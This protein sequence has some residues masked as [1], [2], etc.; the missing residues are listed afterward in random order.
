MDF[1]G[2]HVVVSG[3]AGALGRAVVEQLIGRGAHCHVPAFGTAEGQS[4]QASGLDR[5]D[6]AVGV[7]LTDEAQVRD[8][9]AR[10]PPPWASLHITGG[11]AMAP[12]AETSRADFMGQLEMNAVTC[13]LCCREAVRRMR[14][15]GQGGRIVNVA[16]RPA[17][18]PRTGAGMAAYT[19]SKAAVAA[20][21][22]SLAEEVAGDGIWINAVAPSIMDTPANRGAMPG[23]DFAAWPKV[24][25][26]ATTM[27]HLASPGNGAA[28]GAVVPVYG[29]S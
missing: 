9:Y 8:F 15:G 19:A 23:A 2:R 11:F 14:E 27:L 21:T 20:L 29:R 13:F 7:D 22:Q 18:E 28:R 10:L 16:A 25:E 26:V 24:E 6:V 4:L 3:G 12:L 17:L 1:E 5:L